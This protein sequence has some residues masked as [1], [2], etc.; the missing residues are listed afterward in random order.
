MCAGCA[1]ADVCVSIGAMCTWSW[2][3]NTAVLSENTTLGSL[4]P[5]P[6][7]FS[8]QSLLYDRGST[9][10]CSVSFREHDNIF[11]SDRVKTNRSGF[12]H[13]RRIITLQRVHALSPVVAVSVWIG[14]IKIITSLTEVSGCAFVFE[15]CSSRTVTSGISTHERL[16]QN[17]AVTKTR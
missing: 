9:D 14:V 12:M 13:H 7:A 6:D 10:D 11:E 2:N 5:R 8:V 3:T 4:R 15:G 1:C 17:I 16:S